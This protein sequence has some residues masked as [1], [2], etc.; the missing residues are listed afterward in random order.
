MT[1]D[2]PFARRLQQ[3]A[4]A[5][6]HRLPAAA[7]RALE[8]AA[9]PLGYAVFHVDLEGCA[10]KA[11]LLARMAAALEFP[12]WF[13]HNW[14]ALGDCLGDMSWRPAPGYL[15]FL[16]HAGRLPAGAVA[17]FATAL[18]VCADAAR[19]LAQAGRPMW[20]VIDAA[21]SGDPPR[22]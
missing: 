15:V 9:R 4:E 16:D 19:E 14:D 22:P 20:I 1:T 18:E 10:D 6:I 17:D 12:E 5:G 13:G 3:R 7:A 2:D 11:A 8:A 21:P